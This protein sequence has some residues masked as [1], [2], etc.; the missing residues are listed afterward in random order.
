[1]DYALIQVIVYAAIIIGALIR[2]VQVF[3]EENGSVS[4][5]NITAFFSGLIACI[6]GTSAV[7]NSF[8]ITADIPAL[9]LIL[10]AFLAGYGTVTAI[11][12]AY[13]GVK[14]VLRRK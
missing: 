10:G 7:I 2:F 14:K 1:M 5:S 3:I 6:V 4:G 12:S 8:V 13:K 11:P 9:A